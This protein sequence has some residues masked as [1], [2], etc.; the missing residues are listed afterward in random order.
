LV[1]GT[2]HAWADHR[3]F[4]RRL[5]GRGDWPAFTLGLAAGHR[6]HVVYRT[7]EG[8]EGVDYLVQH[9]NWDQA[10][11]IARD[12]G[13]FSGPGLSWAELVAAAD[14]ARSGGTTSDLHDR[15]LLLLPALGDDAV[16]ECAV[17]RLAAALGARLGV[18]APRP[19]AAALLERQGP[20]G[21][22]RWATA[23]GGVRIDDGGYSFRNPA[24]RFALSDDRL[25]RVS[26]A[27]TP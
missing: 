4:Q 22:S 2:D 1:W 9:T 5:W 26:A 12:D 18:D 3:S 14:N 16:P 20:S 6:L 17:D 19:L 25:E 27:L 11:L 21:P 7:V 23:P 24:N 15:L 10:D 8:E 13:H